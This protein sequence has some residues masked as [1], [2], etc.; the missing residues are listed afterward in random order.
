MKVIVCI[1][2]VARGCACSALLLGPAL[3]EAEEDIRDIRGLKA[4]PGSWVLPAVLAG[5]IVVALCAYLVWRRRHR[6]TRRRSLTLS[7]QVL[8]RLDNTRPL[9]RP[10]T[11]REFGIAASEVIRNYIEKRF[12][13][14][15]TQRTTEEFLQTLLQS[16]NETLAR[17]RS[18]LE[19]FLH[20][21]DLVKFAGASLAVTDMESLFR[22]ARGFVLETGEPPVA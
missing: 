12:D 21:C 14:I 1:R 16:S 9:M 2:R 11:A 20:E 13:V 19:E 15:A 22:S 18:L 7:E 4:V 3:A 17:H 6:E 5:A 8:E 10:A